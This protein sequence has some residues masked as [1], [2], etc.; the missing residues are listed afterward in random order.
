MRLKGA[1]GKD[2][3]FVNAKNGHIFGVSEKKDTSSIIGQNGNLFLIIN[4]GNLRLKAK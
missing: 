2:R 3:A 4:V 1:I